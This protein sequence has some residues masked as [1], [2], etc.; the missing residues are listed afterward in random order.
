ML[1]A[2]TAL[3]KRL[4]LVLVGLAVLTST[5]CVTGCK[6]CPWDRATGPKFSPNP[7]A[8][9]DGKALVYIYRRNHIGGIA[10]AHKIYANG[11]PVTVLANASYYPL[12]ASPATVIFSSG[13]RTA[14]PL[15][16]V[17][18]ANDNLLTL[19]IRSG[20]TYF[21]EFHIGDTWGPKLRLV[22]AQTGFK[23]IQKCRLADTLAKVK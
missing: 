23:R 18:L 19:E 3:R 2:T 1:T 5:V 10:R 20:E 4:T 7:N 6:L 13:S 14:N 22:D 12:V 21:L 9:P 8:I 11:A 16:D 17:A 15:M